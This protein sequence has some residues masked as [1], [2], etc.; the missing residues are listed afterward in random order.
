MG[1]HGSTIGDYEL[2]VWGGGRRAST[3]NPPEIALTY[4]NGQRLPSIPSCGSEEPTRSMGALP[5]SSTGALPF[6]LT[7]TTQVMTTIE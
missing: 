6:P 3:M 1:F 2:G 7:I 5:L 4:D